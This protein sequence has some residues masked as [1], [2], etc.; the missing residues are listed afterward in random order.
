MRLAPAPLA[1]AVAAVLTAGLLA[2]RSFRA[3]SASLK[4]LLFRLLGFIPG[5]QE[6]R[7][8]LYKWGYRRCEDIVWLRTNKNTGVRSL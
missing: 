6:G 2:S 3:R 7:N 5:L 4:L 1:V 8:M